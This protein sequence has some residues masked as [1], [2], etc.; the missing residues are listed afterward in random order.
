MI[1]LPRQVSRS[2][3]K[4]GID[5]IVNCKT[6]DKAVRA[7]IVELVTPVE[8]AISRRAAVDRDGRPFRRTE[9]VV[10]TVGRVP[11]EACGLLV[12]VPTTKTDQK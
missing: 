7:V 10:I 4:S 3:P 9:L 8:P 5:I 6:G 1:C 2:R 12:S 11:D